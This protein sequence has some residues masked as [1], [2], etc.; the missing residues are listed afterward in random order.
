MTRRAA[1]RAKLRPL[2][3]EPDCQEVRQTVAMVLTSNGA[4]Y[5]DKLTLAD[6][7]ACFYASRVLLRIDRKLREDTTELA[8]LDRI[9]VTVTEPAKFTARRNVIARRSRWLHACIWRAYQ[10]DKSRKRKANL[11]RSHRFLQCL[12]SQAGS[13]GISNATIA[14]CATLDGL[15]MAKMRF[16][17]YC[18]TGERLLEKQSKLDIATREAQLTTTVHG[19]TKTFR[20]L[21]YKRGHK[22]AIAA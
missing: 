1:L 13:A 12:I 21:T 3:S 11:T 20:A 7:R 6:W 4:I 5:G 15:R 8:T 9:A 2:L 16:Q 14:D 18:D 22:V 19:E 10:A 17:Q